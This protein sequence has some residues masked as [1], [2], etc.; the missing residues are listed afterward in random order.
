M[1]SGKHSVW[2]CLTHTPIHF[3]HLAPV[4]SKVEQD[5]KFQ[6]IMQDDA[7]LT[8]LPSFLL[9]DTVIYTHLLY[10]LYYIICGG[11]WSFFECSMLWKYFMTIMRVCRCK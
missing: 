5:I 4:F 9:N 1:E 8:A 2:L 11:L 10:L 3:L 7:S 6:Y